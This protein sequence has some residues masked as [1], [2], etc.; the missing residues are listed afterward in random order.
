MMYDQENGMYVQMQ[1]ISDLAI[2][3][4]EGE[5]I[6]SGGYSIFKKVQ[7]KSKIRIIK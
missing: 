1:Q 3:G 2:I 7:I 6:I 4:E 5:L